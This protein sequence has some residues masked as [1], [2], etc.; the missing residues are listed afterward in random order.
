MQRLKRPFYLVLLLFIPLDYMGYSPVQVRIA[1]FST[2]AVSSLLIG[3]ATRADMKAKGLNLVFILLHYY[4]A[5]ALLIGLLFKLQH[6]QGAV[7]MLNVGI[8]GLS[9]SLVLLF[10]PKISRALPLQDET[11]S[12]S[13]FSTHLL[14]AVPPC[15]INAFMTNSRVNSIIE[16]QEGKRT[17]ASNRQSGADSRSYIFARNAL[18]ERHRIP[19]TSR[20]Q[21]L[22][23][24]GIFAQRRKSIPTQSIR[25][26]PLFR[27]S[28]DLL[29]FVPK[30]FADRAFQPANHHCRLWDVGAFNPTLPHSIG[31]FTHEEKA[32]PRH[33]A[34]GG[35]CALE[36]VSA[37]S[38]S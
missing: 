34:L 35:G 20:H 27:K 21:L 23:R 16:K 26:L 33:P 13:I 22:H 29:W 36:L 38:M 12:S 8:S 9:L 1:L 7:L 6:S 24:T 32:E 18:L 11:N 10:V 2:L 25:L 4:G 3:Y 28:G 17:I 37:Y 30:E 14:V 5:S 19:I 15:S 31:S